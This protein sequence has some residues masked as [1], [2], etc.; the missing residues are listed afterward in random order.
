MENLRNEKKWVSL[1]LH[2]AEQDV[3]VL[4]VPAVPRPSP[5][6]PLC[7]AHS[8]RKH[9]LP[10]CPPAALSG[11]RWTGRCHSACV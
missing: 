4:H 11:V 10:T 8:R 2:G 3:E 9:Y 1:D 6:S 5:E 7:P